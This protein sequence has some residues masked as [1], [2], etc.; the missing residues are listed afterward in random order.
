MNGHRMNR[1]TRFVIVAAMLVGVPLVGLAALGDVVI[2]EIAWAG[3]AANHTDEWIE[4]VNTSD[5][6]IDLDGWRL[7]SSDGAPDFLL[8]G[9]LVPLNRDHPGAGYVLLER[10]DDGSVP[11]LSARVIYSGALTDR[12]ESLLLYDSENRLVDTANAR[13]EGADSS[14]AWPSGSGSPGYRTMERVD[15]LLPDAPDNWA[16]CACLADSIEADLFCG[17]P[18]RENS[19]YN[20][21]PIARMEIVPR[22]PQPGETVRFDAAAS[23]DAND[24]ILS[25]EWDFGD[26]GTDDGQTA[27]HAYA[28]AGEY[29][30]VLTA[31]DGRGGSTRLGDALSVHVLSPPLADFSVVPPD[32]AEPLRAGDP[33]VFLDESTYGPAELS[34]RRWTFGDGETGGGERVTHEFASAGSYV[35]RLAIVDARGYEDDR[36]ES[37]TVASRIPEALFT[38]SPERPNDAEL[39]LFDASASADPDG[40]IARFYWDFDGDG[41]TD[42]ITT[43]AQAEYTFGIGGYFTPRLIVEDDNGDRSAP[44]LIP[45]YVN[46]RPVAQFTLSTFEPRE[47]ENVEFV[48]CSH[49]SDGTIQS[50]LWDL[51][52]GDTSVQTSP[53]HTFRS[54]GARTVT[55]TVLDDQGASRTASAT[56]AVINLTPI[57][58]LAV[59][60]HD[61]QTGVPFAFDA[62]GSSDPSPDGGIAGYEWDI[63]GD[64]TYDRQTSASAL[65][66]SYD[67]DGTYRVIVRVTDDRG[68]TAVSEPVEVTVRNRPPSIESIH[69]AP[70]HPTDGNEV[71]FSVGAE[72]P[73]GEIVGWEW[74]LGDEATS[75]SS[76]PIHAFAQTGMYRVTLV[77]RDDDNAKSEAVSIEIDVGNAPPIAE[78]SFAETAPWTVAFNAQASR[79][80]SPS[81]QIVHIAWDFGDG[82]ACPEELS[83]CGGGDRATPVHEYAGPGTYPVTLVV[84]DDDGA[85][86]R[87]LQTLTI[88]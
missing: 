84:I 39:A 77:V 44:S 4:L 78:F 24:E 59:D 23:T 58:A 47:L 40:E 9:I 11:S 83:S 30:V 60:S 57:A 86:G 70:E 53:V 56:I 19:A 16:T 14:F 25:F 76:M 8:H 7:T 33:I 85:I 29:E 87:S 43:D 48:D 13:P 2:N 42:R 12:G 63:D 17:T 88:H 82:S 35:V 22:F 80:P 28:A 74:T 71:T 52:D 38:M 34:E 3:N 54:S 51:G 72:D 5:R 67:D 41:T 32:P 37:I 64:G 65:S 27:S 66:E 61:E 21:L 55:L 68:D 36:S 26:G 62:S 15:P 69:W 46:A 49:D 50:W 10:G 45:I 31:R 20:V 75:T 73:D 79:D 6:P 81:G 18:G 1:R